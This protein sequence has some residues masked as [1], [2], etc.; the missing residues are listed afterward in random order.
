MTRLRKALRWNMNQ[1]SRMAELQPLHE[2]MI[3]RHAMS[4]P[5]LMKKL[6]IGCRLIRWGLTVAHQSQLQQLRHLAFFLT[7]FIRGLI[8]PSSSRN[9]NLLWAYRTPEGVETVTG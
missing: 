5:S 6:L 3:P 1:R 4:I 8:S 2:A 7:T 9:L